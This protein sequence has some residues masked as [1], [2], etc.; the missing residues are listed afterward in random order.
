[1]KAQVA[2][3]FS[4]LTEKGAERIKPKTISPNGLC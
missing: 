4:R 3:T 1:M 2:N